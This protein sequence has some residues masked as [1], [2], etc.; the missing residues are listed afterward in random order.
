MNYRKN[1]LQA[2]VGVLIFAGIIG[3]GGPRSE[4]KENAE[5][6]SVS[7]MSSLIQEYP[8]GS[9]QRYRRVYIAD[10]DATTNEWKAYAA[11]E[12]GHTVWAAMTTL[13]YDFE[14]ECMVLKTACSTAVGEISLE[15]Q[16]EYTVY[17]DE[18]DK[19]VSVLT[20]HGA[21]NSGD[22]NEERGRAHKP[23]KR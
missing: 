22:I 2:A 4:A 9:G 7:N 14:E 11:C 23:Y 20:L 15:V 12:D 6:E 3:L 13:Q 19:I 5:K 1:V 8:S 17:N 21:N 18:G 16:D 10:F